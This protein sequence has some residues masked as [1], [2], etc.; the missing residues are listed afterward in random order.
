MYLLPISGSFTATD[1]NINSTYTGT[2]RTASSARRVICLTFSK[3]GPVS[4]IEPRYAHEARDPHS[5]D[6]RDQG[7]F[8]FLVTKST[9]TDAQKIFPGDRK[10][11]GRVLAYVVPW[12]M[13]SD[14]RYFAAAF[15]QR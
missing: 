10:D 13:V 4:G 2:D 1:R 7:G 14:A 6:M 11:S 15:S 12:N 5:A 3:R 8:Q 9:R